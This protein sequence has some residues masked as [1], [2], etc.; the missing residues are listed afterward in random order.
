MIQVRRLGFVALFL[1]GVYA[2]YG[3]VMIYLHPRFIYPFSQDA[4]AMV[5]FERV[6]IAVRGSDPLGVWVHRAPDPDAA[7]VVY[8]MGNVGTLDIHRAPL[9]LHRDAGRTVVAMTYRGGGGQ[10]GAPSEERLKADALAVYDAVPGLIGAVTDKV[11][12]HGYSMGTGIALHVASLRPVAGIVLDAPYARICDLMRAA[13]ALPACW[14][15]FVQKW[16]NLAYG[17][18]ITAPVL[19]QHGDGD[20]KIPLA[21]A[22]RLSSGLAENGNT[23][24]FNLLKGGTH[25]RLIEIPGYVP[26][27]ESFLASHP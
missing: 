25:G 21:E 22:L 20:T 1:V 18:R 27:L 23:V 16:D 4:F 11:H 2:L 17:D 3:A 26:A 10:P 19:I 5:G 7:I 6:E 8:F 15:P 13:S 9:E 12:V 24:I 14:L